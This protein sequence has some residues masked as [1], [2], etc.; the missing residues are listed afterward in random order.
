VRGSV[1]G[2][3]V[4][5]GDFARVLWSEILQAATVRKGDFAGREC[6]AIGTGILEAASISNGIVQ[7]ASINHLE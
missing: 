4:M 5:Q 7:A 2:A 1:A 3:S 6:L